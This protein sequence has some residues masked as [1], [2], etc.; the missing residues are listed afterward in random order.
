MKD[1][2][3]LDDLGDLAE[4]LMSDKRQETGSEEQ[5]RELYDLPSSNPVRL[6]DRQDDPPTE[7]NPSR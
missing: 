1:E 5:A 6:A 3:P 2:L 4:D 7:K